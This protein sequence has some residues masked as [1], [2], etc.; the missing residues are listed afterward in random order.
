LRW[1]MV[2]LTIDNVIDLFKF[3]LNI[4]HENIKSFWKVTF[5][6][7]VAIGITISSFLL[8]NA[9]SPSYDPC[10]D[11]SKSMIDFKVKN[12]ICVTVE[13]TL[14]I[15]FGLAGF[16]IGKL[17]EI[18]GQQIEKC[19]NIGKDIDNKK[20]EDII[21]ILQKRTKSMK[22]ERDNYF[23]YHWQK[24]DND[25]WKKILDI[26]DNTKPIESILPFMKVVSIISYSIGGLLLIITIG[27]VLKF[28][29][30]ISF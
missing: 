16:K 8:L 1:G 23:D 28:S 2:A 15:A 14:S 25:S 22:E 27:M 18:N 6:L 7:T 19:K 29:I 10:I 21:Q 12:E 26:I 17:T 3:N 13:L 20:D 30:S 5:S 9:G 11:Q 24:I 4:A